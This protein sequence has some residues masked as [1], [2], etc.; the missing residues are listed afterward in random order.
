MGMT[1]DVE[2]PRTESLRKSTDEKTHSEQESQSFGEVP[3][4]ANIIT[5]S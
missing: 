3:L 1:P 5:G 2:G 4:Y